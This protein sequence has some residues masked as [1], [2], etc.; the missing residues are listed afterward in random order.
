MPDTSEGQKK[1]N[2]L[3][4]TIVGMQ[5]D[6]KNL[7]GKIDE[8][9]QKIDGLSTKIEQFQLQGHDNTRDISDMKLDLAK[10]K[11]RSDTMSKTVDKNINNFSKMKSYVAGGVAVLGVVMTLVMYVMDKFD[12]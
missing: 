5:V 2:T 8:V 6:V 7:G 12:W 11:I 10:M 9:C 1:L 4:L 3:E